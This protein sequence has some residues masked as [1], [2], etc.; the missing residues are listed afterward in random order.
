MKTIYKIG[1]LS[2]ILLLVVGV[3]FYMKQGLLPENMAPYQMSQESTNG[4]ISKVKNIMNLPEA[5]SSEIVDLADGATYNLTAGFVKKLIHGKELQLLAYNG[6]IPGP[7]IRAKQGSTVHILFKNMTDTENTIHP[8]GLR[9]ENA[10]DGISNITQAPVKPGESFNYTMYFPDSGVYWYHPHMS[11]SYTQASGLYGDF[12]IIPDAEHAWKDRVDREIP[13]FVSDILLDKNGNLAPFG[14]Q[15][16]KFTLMGR[17]GNM[18]LIN[19]QMNDMYQTTSDGP[20]ITKPEEETPFVV[21]QGEVIRFF[22]TNSANA[23]PFH[24]TIP[25]VK[26]KLI[27]SDG[28]AYEQETWTNAITIG[29]SERYIFEAKFDTVGTFALTNNIPSGKSPVGMISVKADPSFVS[30][31]DAKEFETLHTYNST[32]KSIDPFRSAFDKTPDKNLTLTVELKGMMGGMGKEDIE[33]SHM[34]GGMKGMTDTPP[35]NTSTGI[36]WDSGDGMM[37]MM[38]QVSNTGNVVW[39]VVDTDTKK[40]NMDIHWTFKKGD[41]VKIRIFNDPSSSHA[42]QHPFHFHGQRFLVIDQNGVRQ[43]N[44]VWKDTIMIPSGDTIDILLDASNVGKWMAHC[45]ISEHLEDNMM[46]YFDVT[47]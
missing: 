24:L 20:Y 26:I 47:E 44:L 18:L 21:K 36:E 40:E 33:N 38:N 9:L 16:P 32:I 22:V 12:L 28:G 19:G 6:M 11:E 27:G 41:M 8:H 14:E 15:D 45:H 37:Q 4:G 13:F 43:K 42:M 34:S 29:P 5:K 2:I 39:K 3:I 35:E 46:L 7:T 10:F 30:V 31:S 1:I 17:Y 23:R 25:G